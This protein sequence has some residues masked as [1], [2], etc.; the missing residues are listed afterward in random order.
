MKRYN[1]V[2]QKVIIYTDGT[3]CSTPDELIKSELFETIIQKGLN[4]LYHKSSPILSTLEIDNSKKQVDRLIALFELLAENS[5]ST[6]ER[7]MPQ[8]DNILE[9][10]HALHRLVEFLY[11]YWREFERYVICDSENI[12]LDKHPYR[13]FNR[14]VENLAHLVRKVYRDISEHILNE[15]PRTYRQVNSGA[16]FSCIASPATQFSEDAPYM[17]LNKIP[18]IHQ[19]FMNPPL[20]LDTPMNKRKGQF[21]KVEENPLEDMQIDQKEWLCYPAKVGDLVIFIFFH[22]KF[23]EQGFSACNLFEMASRE[24]LQRKPDAIYLYGVS[25]HSLDSR[26][27]APAVFYED[28]QKDMFIG[29]CPNDDEFGYFGYLKKMVLTLHN[30]IKIKQQKL[31][32]HGSL[33]K[34]TLQNGKKASILMIGD[35]GAGKSETLEAYKELGEDQI[36]EISIIADDMGSIEQDEKGH[37]RGLGTETGAFLRLDDLKPGFAFGQ[38]DRSIIMNAHMTNARIILPVADYSTIRQGTSVDYIFYANN[39]EAVDDDSP[40]IDKIP[41]AEEA[42]KIFSEGKV[43]SKGTTATSGIVNTYF[44]NIFGPAQ[45]HEEH[46]QI[47]KEYFSQFYDNGVFVGQIRT[48][49][50]IHGMEQKGPEIAAKALIELISDKDSSELQE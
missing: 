47:A 6:L 30:A 26:F 16:E 8:K 45:Y 31:P 27:D 17:K 19:V 11:N 50:G 49:L 25:D 33:V 41:S 43:M 40:V 2:N 18:V 28:Q 12:S 32:F 21:L 48:Q 42:I 35:S 4:K 46:H 13:T 9:N 7:I 20:I 24:D 44:A 14:T 3:F 36:S 37:M 1:I 34:I 38:L 29:A 10:K 15:H 23:Y 5:I 39:Y 22:Q